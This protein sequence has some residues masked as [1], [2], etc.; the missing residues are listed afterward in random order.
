M[1]G[2]GE[3]NNYSKFMNDCLKHDCH[4]CAILHKLARNTFWTAVGAWGTIAA[5]GLAVVAILISVKGL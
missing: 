3:C 5:L 2:T 4:D 1:Y